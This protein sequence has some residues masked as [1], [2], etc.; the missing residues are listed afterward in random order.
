MMTE[1]TRMP[2]RSAHHIPQVLKSVLV[3]TSGVTDKTAQIVLR[4]GTIVLRVPAKESLEVCHA[5]GE[6][7]VF[8][9]RQDRSVLLLLLGHVRALCHI[10]ARTACWPQLLLQLLRHE[11]FDLLLL[12]L[13]RRHIRST[14]L[15]LLLLLLWMRPVSHAAAAAAAYW[16]HPLR[17]RETSAPH[18]PAPHLLLRLLLKLL[19][20]SS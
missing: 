6:L 8:R 10:L 11:R 15:L 5:G 16:H 2:R 19:L 20:G 3:P 18:H 13:R 7:V 1:L 4:K 9:F 14:L 12:L 17:L